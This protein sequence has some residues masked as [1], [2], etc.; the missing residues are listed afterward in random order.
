MTQI[1]YREGGMAIRQSATLAINE[2]ILARGAAGEPVLHLGFG[3]AGLPVPPE[4][5]AVLADSVRHNDYGPV[6]GIPAAREAAAGYFTRRGLPTE[7]DQIVM[8]P[9]SKPLLFALLAVLPGDVVLP[10]PSWV[11]YAAQAALLGRRVI[12]VPIPD[13]AGGVPDPDRLAAVARSAGVLILTLPDNP[14]GTLA[15]PDLLAEVCR[16][17]DDAGLVII[18]DEIY[19]DLSHTE[20]HSPAELSPDRTVITSGLSKSLALGGYRIGFTRLPTPL[21]IGADLVGVASEVWSSL[22]SPMQRVAIA[23]LTEPPEVTARIAASRRLHGTVSARVHRLLVR[24]G[25]RCRPPEGGFYLYPDFGAHRESLAGQGIHTDRELADLLL[26]R[27]GVGVLAGAEFGDDPHGLRFRVAT[28]LMYGST[29]E[30][31]LAS[32]DSPDPLAL[33]WI[34]DGLAHLARALADVT[35]AG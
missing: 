21:R 15:P 26:D 25:A 3:E 6:I 35:R 11:S 4:L 32:L 19:R 33:P 18:S 10:V 30:Q 34:A 29:D 5:A 23:A 24:A 13:R 28:S 14:T 31:K 20:F 17:A 2:R 9:G 12:G 27:H 8:A 1:F 22:A 7:P 16:I